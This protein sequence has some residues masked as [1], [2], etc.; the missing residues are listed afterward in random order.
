MIR[1][2]TRWKK[3]QN[4][5]L[6]FRETRD[7]AMV[8]IYLDGAGNGLPRSSSIALFVGNNGWWSM[9]ALVAQGCGCTRPFDPDSRMRFTGLVFDVLVAKRFVRAV[10]TVAARPRGSV[11]KS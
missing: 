10:P 11:R 3:L 1:W 8:F 6:Q 9:G 2:D 5:Y 7:V 4:P